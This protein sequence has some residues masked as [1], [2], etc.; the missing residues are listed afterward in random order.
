MRFHDQSHL[1]LKLRIPWDSN[2]AK[3]F[4]GAL[5]L[6]ALLGLLL[7]ML[8]P[9]VPKPSVLPYEVLATINFGAGDG[10]GLSAGN[11]SAEG[12]RLQADRKA[13]RL[14]DATHKQITP[15][16]P[17]SVHTR[18]NPEGGRIVPVSS[19][20]K[21]HM[22][23]PTSAGRYD[24]SVKIT[25]GTQTAVGEPEGTTDG[26]GRGIKESGSGMGLGYGDIEWSGGGSAIVVRK[27]IPTAPDGLSRSTIV[28]LRFVVSP[29]GE[30]IDVRPLIRGVPEAESA[31]MRAI[32]LWRFRLRKSD[33]TLV[34]VIT[35]RFDVN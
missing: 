10:T 21:A 2:T 26:S 16:S 1:E 29:R 24:A 32:R 34:G 8:K 11:L 7:T 35:F 17:R 14:A 13:P 27:V 31:A 23:D 18:S 12:I 19:N 33:S 4:A 9:D 3:G 22:K 20:N 6:I 25:D 28:K 5:A 15:Q 30:V